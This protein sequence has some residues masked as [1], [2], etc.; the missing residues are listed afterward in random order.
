MAARFVTHTHDFGVERQYSLRL[1]ALYAVTQR[2][3]EPYHVLDNAT[4][5]VDIPSIYNK[6]FHI[7]L[8]KIDRLPQNQRLQTRLA[9]YALLYYHE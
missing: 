1:S 7:L 4:F 5:F 3:F 6:S 8:A 2:P 9:D